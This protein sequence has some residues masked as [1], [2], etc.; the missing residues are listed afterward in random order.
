MLIF[1]TSDK[2][3]PAQFLNDNDI[4]NIVI[5][6]LSSPICGY[7]NL[8]CLIPYGLDVRNAIEGDGLNF[9]MQ[10]ANYLTSNDS[11]FVGIMNL[12]LP[13]FMDSAILIYVLISNSI[14]RDI[15]AESIIKFIQQRYGYC[16]PI[17]AN[18]EDF[19]YITEPTF[20]IPGLINMDKDKFRY[21]TIIG[22]SDPNAIGPLEE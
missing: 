9:D 20:T 15:V 5:Y 21:S 13:V 1:G 4:K 16:A 14:F 12:I 11:A 7:A 22:G 19:L 8:D 3:I 2:I 6:N 10:Y 17:V 18:P